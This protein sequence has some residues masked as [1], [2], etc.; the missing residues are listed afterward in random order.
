MESSSKR[1]EV[2]FEG[3]RSAAFTVSIIIDNKLIVSGS[4]DKTV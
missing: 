1:Q 3:H 4:G 2:I